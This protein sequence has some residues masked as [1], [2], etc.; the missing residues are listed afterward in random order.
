MRRLSSH[1]SSM[2]RA[3]TEEVASF[4]NDNE[5]A[6][7]LSFQALEQI[8]GIHLHYWASYHSHSRRGDQLAGAIAVELT[9]SLTLPRVEVTGM[10]LP[11]LRETRMTTL[12]I[13]HGTTSDQELCEMA[14][15]IARVVTKV[16]H[17]N[18]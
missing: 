4:A 1:V 2:V 18:G 12:H 6:L 13:E 7:V 11:I 9:R 16:F 8:N 17:R 15:Q 3:T 5:V 10:A 14:S